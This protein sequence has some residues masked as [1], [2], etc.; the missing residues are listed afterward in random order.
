MGFISRILGGRGQTFGK[1]LEDFKEFSE[2]RDYEYRSWIYVS[3]EDGESS[4]WI[5]SKV[6]DSLKDT[7][8]EDLQNE[9]VDQI[10]SVEEWDNLRA[11]ARARSIDKNSFELVLDVRDDKI[12]YVCVHTKRKEYGKRY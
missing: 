5:R 11:D 9:V 7:H 6:F 2:E 1:T 12:N 4:Y 8:Y 3:R 10:E